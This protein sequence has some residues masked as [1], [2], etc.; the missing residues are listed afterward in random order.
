MHK[1]VCLNIMTEYEDFCANEYICYLIRIFA[2]LKTHKKKLYI[3]IK[4]EFWKSKSYS[5]SVDIFIYYFY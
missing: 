1:N 4:I 2:I 5:D 3:L